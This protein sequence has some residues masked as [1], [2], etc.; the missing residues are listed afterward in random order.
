MVKR[1]MRIVSAQLSITTATA[2][3]AAIAT[4]TEFCVVTPGVIMMKNMTTNAEMPRNGTSSVIEVI[5]TIV[6]ATTMRIT[7]LRRPGVG[8]SSAR[9][10]SGHDG[11]RLG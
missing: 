7:A 2:S 11:T 4:N 6:V 3:V 5:T 10:D 1:E 8:A 9:R